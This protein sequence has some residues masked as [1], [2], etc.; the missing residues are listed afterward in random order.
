MVL[1]IVRILKSFAFGLN[2]YSQ[3]NKSQIIIVGIPIADNN[4]K[5]R[6]IYQYF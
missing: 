2:N 4:S 5:F 1:I 6:Q 3:I